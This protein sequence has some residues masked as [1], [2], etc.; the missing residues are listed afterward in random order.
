MLSILNQIDIDFFSVIIC[1]LLLVDTYN[2]SEKHLFEYRLFNAL[3][4]SNMILLLLDAAT[5]II[6]GQTFIN[7]TIYIAINVLGYSMNPVPSFLWLLYANYQVFSNEKHIRK[8]FWPFL[9]PVIINAM[10]ALITPF[11]GLLFYLDK[12]NMYHRGPL[13]P[14]VVG[15]VY[16][17]VICAFILILHN[18]NKIDKR[19]F[20]A[21][22]CF[23]IPP[24]LC[25]ILQALN[26]G[27]VLL[28]SS[29]TLSLLIAYLSIQNRKLH[30]DYLTGICN[31]MQFDKYLQERISNGAS[32]NKF[33]GIL[34]DI[35][36]FKTINDVYGHNVGDEALAT[37]ADLLKK[38]L[39]QD[40]FLARYGGDEF[41]AILNVQRYSDLTKSVERIHERIRN[42]NVNANKPYQLSLS[43]GY[44]IYDYKSGMDKD[45]FVKH[46][47]TLMYECKKREP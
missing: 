33:G 4:I 44:D 19:S 28:W 38:S 17:Y 41:I 3:L 36:N 47:D 43:M 9:V 42:Y 22:L 21:L 11:T 25:G 10:I 16:A 39:R 24:V 31:R 20:A 18:R 32:Q 7:P 13:F 26:Y 34:L 37:I 35:D 8:I 1:G 15:I 2:R 27:L 12:N 23:S 30:T 29:V 46:I 6:D 45:Q 14:L 40:D 5:W